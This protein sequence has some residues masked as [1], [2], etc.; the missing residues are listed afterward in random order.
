MNLKEE[1]KKLKTI[2]ADSDFKVALRLKMLEKIGGEIFISQVK[3]ISMWRMIFMKKAVLVPIVL[4]VAILGTGIG[5]VFASQSALP[6][7]LLYPIKTAT[8]KARVAL[9]IN[10]NKKNELRLKFIERRLEEA[11]KLAEKFAEKKLQKPELIKSAVEAYENELLR[12][13]N[14]VSK[15]VKARYQSTLEKIDEKIKDQ[16]DLKESV[17]K[18]KEKTEKIKEQIKE[19]RKELK[20]EIKELRS[21]ILK[22]RD[23]K[24]GENEKDKKDED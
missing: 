5:G 16:Q 19:D 6:G 2:K 10:K 23:V 13:E 12:N 8:E 1:L 20:E 9:V 21:S 22:L 7:D 15:E 14:L 3:P 17:K 24:S 18:A 4:I 11:E